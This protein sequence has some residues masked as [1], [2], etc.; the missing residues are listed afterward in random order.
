M[1]K[2]IQILNTSIQCYFSATM[3]GYSVVIIGG[4]GL[5][6]ALA[7]Q[8]HQHGELWFDTAILTLLSEH[9]TLVLDEF[10]LWITWA[11]SK[12]FLLPLSMAIIGILIYRRHYPEAILM[13]IGFGG[14]SLIN[15][16]L[17]VLIVRERPLLFLPLEE[18]GGF[19]F[20]SGHTAQI[21]AFA[22]S[23]FL[24]I[25]RLHPRWQWPTAILLI[26]LVLCVSTSRLYLQVHYPSDILG[27]FLVALVWIFSIDA[28]I[29]IINQSEHYPTEKEGNNT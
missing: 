18:Y 8:V 29:H 25:H 23:A 4:I 5:F 3:L 17:K 11:G 1:K 9:R 12:F 14:A 28:L 2:S 26:I 24:I 13:G 20:P 10:F 6:I 19:A 22:L 27:G 21:T 16:A 7:Q 15:L